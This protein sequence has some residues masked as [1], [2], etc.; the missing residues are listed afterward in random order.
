M[1]TWSCTWSWGPGP[2][3]R[4]LHPI[5]EADSLEA[6]F[7]DYNGIACTCASGVTVHTH[8]RHP[9]LMD[10]TTEDSQTCLPVVA[11]M[12]GLPPAGKLEANQ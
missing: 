6:G 7:Q 2:S 4:T 3:E 8:T 11:N 9:S 1:F 10:E 12:Y 5:Q